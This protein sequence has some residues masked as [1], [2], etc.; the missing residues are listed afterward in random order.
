ME[1]DRLVIVVAAALAL[2][3]AM[4]L[5]ARGLGRWLRRWQARRRQ[6]RAVRGERHAERLLDRQGFTVCGRQVATSW[7]VTCDGEMH[8]VPLRADLIV[9][10]HGKRYVAEVKT[11]RVAP[12][13][14]TTATRRQL[15]E[16]RVAY[17]VDGILLVDAEAGRV[18]HVDFHLPGRSRAVPGARLVVA[19]MWALGV[20]AATGLVAGQW[21][22][23]PAAGEQAETGDRE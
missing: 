18:M 8:E 22:H 7:A 9:E 15:L 17:D 6:V 16:Y 11:G 12:R 4:H 10:R 3:V 23:A 21:L 2:A 20:G 14:A 13:L 5:V 1:Q 19:V